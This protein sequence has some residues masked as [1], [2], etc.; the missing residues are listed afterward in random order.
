MEMQKLGFEVVLKTFVPVYSD[1]IF[2]IE[3]DIELLKQSAEELGYPIDGMV[4]GY[5]DIAYGDSLGAT[6]HH[7]RSQMAFKFYDE[8]VE[9]KLKAIDWTMGK[10]GILTPTAV[11]QPVEIEG[12]TVERASLH[13]VSIMKE[14]QLN[15]G[16]TITVYKANQIIPQVKENL[17]K[18]GKAKVVIP[19]KCPICGGSTILMKENDSEVLMCENAD[20]RGKLLGKLSHAVSRNALNIDGM[21]EA[22]I[23]KFIDLG[24][25]TSIKDIYHLID[26]KTEME[27]LDGLSYP[28]L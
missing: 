14:L 19:K 25:L 4:L 27:S 9:T 11:F 21:S 13:N 26:H 8:E 10:T 18:H 5:K 28:C 12:T 15:I 1:P 7:L 3:N 23:Q 17:T 20:C 24:W 22:T 16:D 2:G 6:G